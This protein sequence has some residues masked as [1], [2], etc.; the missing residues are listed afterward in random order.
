VSVLC[1]RLMMDTTYIDVEVTS[2]ERYGL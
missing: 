2:S 1:Y